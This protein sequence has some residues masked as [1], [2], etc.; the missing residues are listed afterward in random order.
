MRPRS[1]R[2]TRPRYASGILT[3]LRAIPL[4]LRLGALCPSSAPT[5]DPSS[6]SSDTLMS[7]PEGIATPRTRLDS[8]EAHP[9]LARQLRVR[10]HKAL[11]SRT[12][13]TIDA[14][15]LI[16]HRLKQTQQLRGHAVCRQQRPL[17][18]TQLRQ[19]QMQ[20]TLMLHRL[21]TLGH[22]DVASGRYSCAARSHGRAETF[23]PRA[24]G[25][26]S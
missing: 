6:Q 10:L 15:A 1:Y 22:P 2:G 4:S 12:R 17:R 20:R 26:V 11:R 21:L 23:L 9:V 19:R 13:G 7:L 16:A 5:G 8:R 25:K 18:V 24:L 14:H 3:S